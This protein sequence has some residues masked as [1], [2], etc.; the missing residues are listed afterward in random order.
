MDS[1]ELEVKMKQEPEARNTDNGKPAGDN[2][3]DDRKPPNLFFRYHNRNRKFYRK[4]R[5]QGGG[6]DRRYFKKPRFEVG[7]RLKEVDLGITE[8]VSDC[9]GFAGT[10]KEKFTDFHVH[11]IT[12]AGTIAKLTDLSIPEE[13]KK[14][15]EALRKKISPDNWEKIQHIANDS[16]AVEID[17]T[18]LDKD[19]RK[20]IHEIVKT[21]TSVQSSTKDRDG[22]KFI[23]F[24]NPFSQNSDPRARQYDNRVD[25]SE[26]GG[27]YVHFIL[28]KSNMDTMDALNQLARVLRIK[29]SFFCY[30]GTKDR[31][32]KTSQWISIKKVNPKKLTNAGRA[33]RGAYVGNFKYEKAP[34]RLGKL[35]GNRFTIALRN[36][37]ASNE[38][39]DKAMSS[40]RDNGFINYY[41]LQRFGTIAAIPTYLIGKAILQE[42][43][44]EAI[45]LIL[46][47][48]DGEQDHDLAEARK[49]YQN[50]G[51][52]QTAHDRI[53][54]VDKIEAKL[55]WAIHICGAKNPQGAL[56]MIPR[57]TVLIYIHAYQSYVWNQVVS[58]R[59][60]EFGLTPIVGD[61]VYE[62]PDAT[63]DDTNHDHH[64]ADDEDEKAKTSEVKE[65]QKT[66]ETT[67]VPEKE[68]D[69]E[70]KKPL[71]RKLSNTFRD[72]EKMPPKVK[73]LTAEDLPNYNIT[74][75]VL[76]QPGWKIVYP[77]YAKPW[78]EEYLSK[79]GLDTDLKQK[80][81]KYT[82]GGAYRKIIEVPTDFT[83]RIVRH[84]LKDD[85]L[86]ASDIDEM[87]DLKAPGDNSDGK[88]KA[89]VLQ[90]S[91]KPS[92]Y[93]TMA[94]REILKSDTS[95][96]AH[97]ARSAAF[98]A[99]Q[100]AN[101]ANNKTDGTSSETDD[102]HVETLKLKDEKKGMKTKDSCKMTANEEQNH[103]SQKMT[104]EQANDSGIEP[105]AALQA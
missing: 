66:D 19:Q 39:L 86:I 76:P 104:S 69:P 2:K 53:N 11:E 32:A 17:V 25:W 68:A 84:M 89:V 46:K 22:K 45:D 97:A 80:N 15:L 28:H 20:A 3:N 87:K 12:C 49:M 70:D 9:E 1:V 36:V 94:L 47:P 57:N 41:G 5:Y 58:R 91:M 38:I 102:I 88:F 4:N 59:I 42:K 44:A 51:D 33:I 31:R 24:S 81:K 74:D 52:A 92:S 99:E 50:T 100:E 54:R 101:E 72:D 16:N 30:A 21:L 79:D 34:L 90:F 43:W 35:A 82:L 73:V 37:G 65:E 64:H 29:S 56:D 26:R 6:G 63:D 55:L 83:W 95:A 98:H 62:N 48:R 14:D 105:G 78:Y 96:Q 18:N 40:L 67:D 93:A 23:V 71:D 13:P 103:A 75:I 10:M 7:E 85:D 77:D 60:N 27:D 61:L 8:Y